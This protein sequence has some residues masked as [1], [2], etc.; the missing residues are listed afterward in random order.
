[1]MPAALSCQ[2]LGL[3]KVLT[4]PSFCVSMSR[5]LPCTLHTQVLFSPVHSPSLVGPSIRRK[6]G[7]CWLARPFSSLI[8][9]DRCRHPHD[10]PPSS[11]PFSVIIHPIYHRYHH[12]LL[13]CYCI[14]D[15]AFFFLLHAKLTG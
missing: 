11:F 8:F 10:P 7:L 5:D 13:C 4:T 1:M 9:S 6:P 2:K 14:A 12:F 15:E 3:L